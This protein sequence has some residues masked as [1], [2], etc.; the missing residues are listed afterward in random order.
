MRCAS[1]DLKVVML[2]KRIVEFRMRS[3]GFGAKSSPCCAVFALQKV[4]ADNF[5]EAKEKVVQAVVRTIYVDDRC[6]SC[7]SEDNSFA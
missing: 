4:A 6:K 5:T 7:V 1:F 2:S 3:N